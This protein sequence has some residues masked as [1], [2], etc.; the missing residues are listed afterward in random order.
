M[1]N[2]KRFKPIH[3]PSDLD[4][5][6]GYGPTEP[7]TKQPSELEHRSVTNWICTFCFN[8]HFFRPEAVCNVCGLCQHCGIYNG[9]EAKGCICGNRL[10]ANAPA[11]ITRRVRPV[12]IIA[13]KL[14]DSDNTAGV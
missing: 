9:P 12:H 13:K 14:T 3:D 8:R 6:A 10:P 1:K 11:I 4:P 2:S 5:S 7:P